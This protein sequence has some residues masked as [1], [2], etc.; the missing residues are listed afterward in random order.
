MNDDV[1]FGWT[2]NLYA[3]VAVGHAYAFDRK[4]MNKSWITYNDDATYEP[5]SFRSPANSVAACI[6]AE[7]TK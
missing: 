1:E 7:I 4:L 6:G 2:A 3:W 5:D